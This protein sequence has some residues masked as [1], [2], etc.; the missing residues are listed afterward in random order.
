[1]FNIDRVIE[2]GAIGT[3]LTGMAIVF[4]GL[5][6]I[7]VYIKILPSILDLITAIWGSQDAVVQTSEDSGNLNPSEEHDLASVIGLVM[8]LE[9]QH[10]QTPEEKE[11]KEIASVIGLVL[12]MEQ[13]QLVALPN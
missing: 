11:E 8:Q 6:L 7:S 1:M 10:Q 13:D 12:Q 2:G 4:S 9:A 5:V 3:S